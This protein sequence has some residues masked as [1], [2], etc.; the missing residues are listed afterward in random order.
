[1]PRNYYYFAATLPYINYGDKPPISSVDFREECYRVL[2]AEDA[3][4][5]E[6][7][8]YDPQVAVKTVEPTGSEFIDF[9]IL[10]ER[11]LHLSLAFL[12][13]GRLKRPSQ[14]EPPHDVPRAE[15]LARSAFE[16]TDPLEAAMFIDRAR[17]GALDVELP[18]NYSS[19]HNIFGYLLKLQLLERRGRF[20]AE[21]GI[22]EFHV[23]YDTILNEYNSRVR[24]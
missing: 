12:R 21:K 3:A 6:Y 16:M 19:V 20:D 8:C 2:T 4:L 13:A 7:C 22:A 10:R 17:W 15:A 18:I 1:M 5:T 14:E 11:I 9:F 23:C 24:G